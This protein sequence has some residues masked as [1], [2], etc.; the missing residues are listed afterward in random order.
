MFCKRSETGN[1][2]NLRNPY[3]FFQWVSTFCCG[4]CS[5][6]TMAGYIAGNSLL[7]AELQ[8]EVDLRIKMTLEEASWIRKMDKNL[9][10]QSETKQF[11]FFSINLGFCKC[12]RLYLGGL[13]FRCIWTQDTHHPVRGPFHH[14][15]PVVRLLHQ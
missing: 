1:E 6:V 10:E 15:L 12:W 9:Q 14:Q 3:S 13:A 8:D 2:K 4:F 5:G 7:V 11:Q